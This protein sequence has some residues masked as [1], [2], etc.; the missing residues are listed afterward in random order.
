MNWH[1]FQYSV[2]WFD[3]LLFWTARI[4]VI[5]FSTYLVRETPGSHCRC[6]NTPFQMSKQTKV[7]NA[8]CSKVTTHVFILKAVPIWECGITVACSMIKT[9]KKTSWPDG[10][11]KMPKNDV[12]DTTTASWPRNLVLNSSDLASKVA[13]SKSFDANSALA[14]LIGTDWPE[15]FN[16]SRP[17]LDGNSW[18]W[19]VDVECIMSFVEGIHMVHSKH[20]RMKKNRAKQLKSYRFFSK[21]TFHYEVNDILSGNVKSFLVRFVQWCCSLNALQT[22]ML[23]TKAPK[24]EFAKARHLM[25]SCRKARYVSLHTCQNLTLQCIQIFNY[26][27]CCFRQHVVLEEKAVALWIM[28]HYIGRRQDVC[29]MRWNTWELKLPAFCFQNVVYTGSVLSKNYPQINIRD[30]IFCISKTIPAIQVIWSG[31]IFWWRTATYLNRTCMAASACMRTIATTL[32][33]ARSFAVDQG[34]TSGLFFLVRNWVWIPHMSM[35]KY[36]L[37]PVELSYAWPQKNQNLQQIFPGKPAWLLHL[38][39]E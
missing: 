9:S 27:H 5:I 2:H 6:W 20:P 39:W 25:S 24:W 12:S 28:A 21:Q 19:A 32:S 18:P 23:G 38:L 15:R 36:A 8:C 33:Q 29:N 17:S 31:P 4:S 34:I 13:C 37:P 3:T 10:L 16:A 14:C 35:Y 1:A 26:I 30:L 22:Q 7:V 11:R